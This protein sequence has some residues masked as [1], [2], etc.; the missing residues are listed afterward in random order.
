MTFV[1]PGCDGNSLPM[2]CDAMHSLVL[3]QH[4]LLSTVLFEGILQSSQGFLA[5]SGKASSTDNGGVAEDNSGGGS[6][7]NHGVCFAFVCFVLYLF[8][9]FAFVCMLYGFVVVGVERVRVFVGKDVEE[10]E[11]KKMKM[12]RDTKCRNAVQ[13]NAMI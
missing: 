7:G 13:C 2:R 4:L 12:E 6:G 1:S 9:L 5:L 10:E 8:V 3:F 11:K